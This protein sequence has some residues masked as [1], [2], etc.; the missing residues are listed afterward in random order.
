MRMN[1]TNGNMHRAKENDDAT[2]KE[3]QWINHFEC[4]QYM[5]L[6]HWLNEKSRNPKE[7]FILNESFSSSQR[8]QKQSQFHWNCETFGLWILDI[9]RYSE[10]G[11]DL[12][13]RLLCFFIF[14]GKRYGRQNKKLCFEF[15]V[16]AQ[17]EL[18]KYETMCTMQKLVKYHT[19][20]Y[21]FFS[22]FFFFSLNFHERGCYEQWQIHITHFKKVQRHWSCYTFILIIV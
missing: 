21:I 6:F 20:W 19:F 1:S 13:W 14:A 18:Q 10:N 16:L 5:Y 3:P 17:F 8:L 7:I 15:S 4:V 12:W 22:C 9:H 2:A 11:E